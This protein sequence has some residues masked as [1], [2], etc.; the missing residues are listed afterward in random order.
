MHSAWARS[1]IAFSGWALVRYDLQTR[2]QTVTVI[3]REE[4]LNY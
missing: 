2:W 3:V 1:A 4:G